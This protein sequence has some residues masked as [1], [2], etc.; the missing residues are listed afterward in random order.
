MLIQDCDPSTQNTEAGRWRTK[1]QPGL[2]S[3]SLSL[4]KKKITF[5]K[6]ENLKDYCIKLREL[7]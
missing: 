1:D 3:E 6:N 4:K 5:L 7:S 2:H